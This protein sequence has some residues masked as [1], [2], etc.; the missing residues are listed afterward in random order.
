M[1]AACAGHSFSAPATR[2]TLVDFFNTCAPYALCMRATYVQRAS[3]TLCM[4]CQLASF[5]HILTKV[6]RT[7]THWQCFLIFLCAHRASRWCDLRFK[8]HN[9]QMKSEM[10]LHCIEKDASSCP[11]HESNFEI[12]TTKLIKLGGCPFHGRVERD[13]IPTREIPPKQSGTLPCPPLHSTPVPS[14]PLRPL[15]LPA[16]VHLNAHRV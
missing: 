3:N 4:R 7:T 1:R 12:I 11:F 5:F 8:V 10:T 16:A 9:L 13:E 15:C 14:T 2:C 6:Q